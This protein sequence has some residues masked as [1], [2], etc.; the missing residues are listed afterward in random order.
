MLVTLILTY[1]YLPKY[2]YIQW[3][4]P[5]VLLAKGTIKMRD[6]LVSFVIFS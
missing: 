5:S 4:F 6:K 1:Q 2:T 3:V